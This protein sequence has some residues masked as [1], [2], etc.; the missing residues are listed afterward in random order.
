M[1]R[2]QHYIQ[3][4][5]PSNLNKLSNYSL[6]TKKLVKHLDYV[7]QFTFDELKVLEMNSHKDDQVFKVLTLF[8]QAYE[9]YLIENYT[10]INEK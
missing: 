10:S 1:Y 2:I 9:N 8:H 3:N 7:S 6:L 5:I 4:Q